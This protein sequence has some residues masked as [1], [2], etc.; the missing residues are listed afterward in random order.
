MHVIYISLK[1]LP[2]VCK[3]ALD[4]SRAA[5]IAQ[6][7]A[8]RYICHETFIEG[9]TQSCKQVAVFQVFYYILHLLKCH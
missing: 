6:G 1:A 9:C 4:E 2:P 3:L 5:N 8:V 7:E